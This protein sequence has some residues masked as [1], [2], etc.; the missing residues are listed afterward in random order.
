MAMNDDKTTS[1]IKH[2]IVIVGE[3]RSFDHEYAT[4][5]AAVGRQR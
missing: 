1:P 3:N 4:Y 2:V 5:V